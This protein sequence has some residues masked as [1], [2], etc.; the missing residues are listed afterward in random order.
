[1]ERAAICCVRKASKG[2]PAMCDDYAKAICGA[3]IN[4]CFLSRLADD[5]ITQ[6]SVEIPACGGFMLAERTDEHLSHFLENI[7]AAYFTGTEE[8][9]QKIEYYL[10]YE[11]ERRRIAAAGRKKCLEAGFSY[12]QRIRQILE[13]LLI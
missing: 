4:L 9:C 10:N 13:M 3:K 6:R 7:E 12:D 5:A 2:K 11:K 1:M 8:M